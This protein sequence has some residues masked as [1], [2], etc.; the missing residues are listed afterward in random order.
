MRLGDDIP[1]IT[2]TCAKCGGMFDMKFDL[3]CPYCHAIGVSSVVL[4]QPPESHFMRECAWC[5]NT[6]Y[7]NTCHA[8]DN[9]PFYALCDECLQDY[10]NGYRPDSQ[11]HIVGKDPD[12]DW[13]YRLY[14]LDSSQCPH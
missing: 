8:N 12:V 3:A 14:A 1:H 7:Q 2:A 10:L 5:D 13:L 9:R 11:E 6:T 4:G